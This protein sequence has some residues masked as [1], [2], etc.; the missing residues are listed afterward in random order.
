MKF[1]N[2][3]M[4]RFHAS[5]R[6]HHVQTILSKHSLTVEPFM[7]EIRA[8][9]LRA[10]EGV[11]PNERCTAKLLCGPELWASYGANSVKQCAG[12][13]LSYLVLI[14]ALPLRVHVTPKGKGTKRYFLP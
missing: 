13:C 5:W 1:Q 8:T 14:R 6:G 7:A 10:L 11:G 9:V 12:M 3:D 4:T 2:I